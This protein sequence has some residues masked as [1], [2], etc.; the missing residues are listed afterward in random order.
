M[1]EPVNK[2]LRIGL[3]F[4][5]RSGEH[6]VS[7]VSARSILDALD[8]DRYEPVLIGI[9]RQGGWHVTETNPDLL[10]ARGQPL[11]LD[12]GAP[13]VALAPG[14]GSALMPVSGGSTGLSGPIDVF[15]PVLHGTYGEDGTIQGLLEMA[16]VPYVGSGVL[17]SAVGMDKDVAKRLLRDAGI[18]VVEFITV[19]AR[20]ARA[21][22]ADRVGAELGYPCFVKPANMGSS[23]GVHRVAGAEDL[24]AAVDDA[25][26]YDRKILIERAVDAR[27]IEC[28]VLG[29]EEARASVPGEIVP[30]DQFYS[31]RAKYVDENGAALVIPADLDEAASARVR[32]LSIRAFEVLELCGMARVDFLLDRGSGELYLN[33]V[34]TIPGFT[35]ISMYPKLW[36]ASGLSYAELV[37]RLVELALERHRQRQQLRTEYSE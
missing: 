11:A 12:E 29:N 17:G 2:K 18:P 19:R 33:E 28:S 3:V 21:P 27:E 15:F 8:R 36:E 4:G 20:D 34:N 14:E 5:G 32:E 7:L 25:F 6:E 26:A 10:E 24:A 22:L 9:D 35:Q 1:T 23:V 13:T 31:Y 37:D 16:N 30:T